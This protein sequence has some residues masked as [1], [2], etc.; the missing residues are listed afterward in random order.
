MYPFVRKMHRRRWLGY[1][2]LASLILCLGMGSF[3]H[4]FQLRGQVATAQ[5]INPSHLVQ[6]G[7]DRYQS[8][9]FK[10]AI[11]PWQTALSI[12]Q[13][14]NDRPSIAI[15]LENLARAYQKLGQIEQAI[16]AWQ[17]LVTLYRQL[18]DPGKR[19]RM[20]TELAQAHS[21]LGQHR[22]AI[23]LLCN[24][25]T[26]RDTGNRPIQCR[27]ESALFIAQNQGD[28]SSEVAALGNLGRAYQAQGDYDQAIAWLKEGLSIAQETENL[29]YQTSLFGSL[30]NAY[31]NRAQ[32]SYRRAQF[33]GQATERFPV[34]DLEKLALAEFRSPK[35]E[36]LENRAIKDEATALSY[37]EQ[38]FA[39]AQ[40]QNNPSG[41]FQ[42]LLHEIPIYVR[43]QQQANLLSA[44]E[45]ALDLIKDLPDARDTV[46]GAINLAKLLHNTADSTGSAPGAQCANSNDNPQTQ[47]LLQNAILM[48]QRIGDRRAESFALG[49]LGHVYECRQDFTQAL[50]LTQQARWVAADLNNPDS[51]YLWEWQTGRILGQGQ[52]REEAGEV[53]S[54]AIQFYEQAITTLEK[55][56][57]DILIANR[58]LQFDFRDTI[59]PIYRELAALRLE[60]ESLSPLSALAPKSAQ[61]IS[62]VITTIDSLKLAELQNYFGDDCVL[63]ALPETPVERVDQE[64]AVISTIILP[65]RTAVILNLPNGEY[66]LSWIPFQEQFV[67]NS[68]NGYRI[69]LQDYT[70][71]FNLQSSQRL[72]DWLV[73]PF[74]TE[75]VNN[76]IKT[77]VFVQDGIFRS[78]PMSALHD[79]Q[80]YLI[81]KYAIATTPSLQLTAPKNLDRKNLKAMILGLTQ[82]ATID[83]QDFEALEYVAQEIEGIQSLL[84]GSRQ[85]RDGEFT[86]DRLQQELNDRTYPI[87]HIATHAEFG[88]DPEDTFLVLG[89]N[90][91]LAINEFDRLIRSVTGPQE[92]IELLTLTACKTAVGDDRAALGLAGVAIQAGARSTVA[93][94][95]SISDAATAEVAERFYQE[96]LNPGVNKAEALRTAQLN[97]L[98]SGNKYARPAYWA[99]FVLIGNWL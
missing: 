13:K 57:S 36:A 39:I 82:A 92:P 55:I 87:V 70:T 16:D 52:T 89:N 17:Q 53:N 95:W 18:D 61:N 98:E 35:I 7:V 84:P 62:Q 73:R 81:Q 24:P 41:M 42:V 50:D 47:A 2:F 29:T 25:L 44:Q 69:D 38:S 15:V 26:D 74:T 93:S 30:G 80:Q 60:R 32:L 65:G 37:F 83:N 97:L 54:R 10:G 56:R 51:L 71:P 72:Y 64:T 21:R 23:T 40:Q 19:G 68:I 86:R 76:K 34:P 22:R 33:R 58:D 46:F 1:L 43:K 20:L 63:T 8:G 79:G 59:E 28:R 27:P 90:Q 5:P 48:A 49:E 66:R 11:E 96:L 99:P 31:A 85:L 6:Q 94:L 67:I 3:S 12:Y 91:K 77:L 9:N 45:T 14:S 88:P 78:V 75:L 4:F